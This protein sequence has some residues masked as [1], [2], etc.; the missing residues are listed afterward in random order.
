METAKVY[1]QP[2]Y[3]GREV[4]ALHSALGGRVE[5][6]RG[7]GPVECLHVGSVE[8][9]ES[10]I[11]PRAPEF[12]PPWTACAWHRSIECRRAFVKSASGYKAREAFVDLVWISEPVEFVDEWRHYCA[13]GRSLCSWWYQGQ[14]S[15]CEEDPHG[16]GLPFEL[17]P[18]FCG[19]V[20]IGRL[21]DGR[22]TL[23]E[24]GHPYAIGW[25]GE[26]SDAAAYVAFLIR[27]WESLTGCDPLLA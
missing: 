26:S 11:G 13:N 7:A 15:T 6:V 3:E 1:I 5:F 21:D 22:V 12:Y 23:V 10:V 20:D 14:E 19:A 17:P 8:F 9:I 2:G 27:G 16:P 4:L 25:Y 24:V 18:G